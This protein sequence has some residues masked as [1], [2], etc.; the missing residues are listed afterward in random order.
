MTAEEY[1]A[2]FEMITGRTGFNDAALEDAYV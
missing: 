2:N 1:T